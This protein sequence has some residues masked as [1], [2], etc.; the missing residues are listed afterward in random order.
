M[1]KEQS[2][3]VEQTDLDTLLEILIGRVRSD[4]LAVLGFA[5]DNYP[6]E[7]QDHRT[8]EALAQSIQRT[9]ELLDAARDRL[10]QGCR[11]IEASERWTFSASPSPAPARRRAASRPS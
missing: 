7:S 3:E 6:R 9:A 5:A 10:C 11:M 2:V 1:A 8:L 4:G